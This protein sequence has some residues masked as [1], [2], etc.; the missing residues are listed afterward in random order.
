MAVTDT[1]SAITGDSE[2]SRVYT[3]GMIEPD[4]LEPHE[5]V[6]FDLII[7]Q[8]LRVMETIYLEYR[9]GLIPEE[10]W[11]GQWRG[12]QSILKTKGGRESWERQKLF[13]SEGFLKWVEGSFDDS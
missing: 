11:L 9:E 4:S 2:A 13:V 5:R 1:L 3:A 7:Y 6:R 10:L 8:Q 12:Q